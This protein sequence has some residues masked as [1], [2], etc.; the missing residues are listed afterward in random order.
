MSTTAQ[1][2]EK[3]H[4]GFEGIKAALYLGS[5]GV[6][7]NTAVGMQ[8]RLRRNGIG[9]R[10]SGKERDAET[11]LDYFGARYFSSPQG[12]FTSPDPLMASAHV[13]D[14]QSWNRYAYAGNNPLKYTD[15]LGL[16]PS[17]A[18]NC[19]ETQKNC[20]NDDQR[21]ILEN[22]Q[23]KIGDET[24][25]GQALW[26]YYNGQG[27]KG[28][29]IQNAFVNV[30]DSLGSIKLGDGSTALSQVSS[31]TALEPDRIKANISGSVY[32][33]I[34]QN[35]NFESVSGALHPGF[36]FASFKSRDKEG[37]IQFSFAPP[38][39]PGGRPGAADIDHDLYNDWRHAFEVIQN[40]ATGGKTN[41]DSIRKILQQ[42]PQVGITPSTD[43][44]WN[45]R[46]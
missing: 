36:D 7:S 1:L 24:Y 30:T 25:S 20:L 44:K 34:S 8:L 18:Y 19:S 23:V 22:S 41:Q 3:S 37:N 42:R 33:S 11:G 43:S 13:A 27:K 21:R 14:P 31:V 45:S 46:K 2:S 39:T 28:E 9:S 6:K 35:K 32:D 4:R 26:D 12:R 10:S 40:H 17:P 29:A 16:F 5:T 15:P 38:P